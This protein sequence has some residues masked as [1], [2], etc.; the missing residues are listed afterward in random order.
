MANFYDFRILSELLTE[1]SESDS[2]RFERECSMFHTNVHEMVIQKALI[3]GLG[4]TELVVIL[5]I[6]L[7]LFGAGKLPAVGGSIGKAIRNF[8]DEM[9]GSEK[10]A[11]KL[12]DK[13]KDKSSK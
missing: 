3:G 11:D 12:T 4:T 7:V 1:F 9:K 5:V 6:I 8:K 2:G 10:P 13:T